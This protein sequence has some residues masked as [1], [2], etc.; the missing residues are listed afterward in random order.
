MAFA[1]NLIASVPWQIHLQEKFLLFFACRNP[2]L[3]AVLRFL[4]M[5][6]ETGHRARI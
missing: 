4:S 2:L 5:E 6:V 1:Y 3:T